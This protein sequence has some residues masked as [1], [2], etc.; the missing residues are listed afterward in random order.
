MTSGWGEECGLKK[1]IVMSDKSM[2][3]I[4]VPFITAVAVIV[5]FY[6]LGFILN[7][8]LDLI[9]NIGEVSDFFYLFGDYNSAAGT[10]GWVVAG[11]LWVIS[12]VIFELYTSQD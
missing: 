9:F 5:V 12:T 6:V 2:A 3:Q 10:A 1:K 8:I 4:C 7:V 11:I